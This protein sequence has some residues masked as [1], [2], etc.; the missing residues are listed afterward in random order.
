[1]QEQFAKTL[2][3]VAAVGTGV[4]MLGMTLTGALAQD[5]TLADFPKPFTT[6]TVVV[7]GSAAD[8]ADNTA[9]ADI[10]FALGAS[11]A[12]NP[13]ST[14]PSSTT[15]AMTKLEWNG[16]KMED[17]PLN[18]SFIDATDGFRSNLTDND[19][20]GFKDDV[21]RIDIGDIDDDY[22]FHEEVRFTAGARVET[23]L[24]FDSNRDKDWKE[25]IFLPMATSSVGYYFTFDES[26]K[27]G[28]YVAN[29]TQTDPIDITFLGKNLQLIGLVRDADSVTINVGEEFRLNA[30]DCVSVSGVKV[31]LKGTSS[32]KAEVDIGGQVEVITQDSSRT[33]KGVEVR[34]EDVFDEEGTSL[35]SATVFIGKDARKTYNDGQEFIGE[36][37]NDPIWVWDLAALDTASPSIGVLLNLNLDNANEDD[38]AMVKHPLYEGEYLCLPWNYA[39]IIFEKVEQKD[40]DFLKYTLQDA[41]KDLYF[42]TTDADSGKAANRTAAKV[43][44]FKAQGAN[45]NGFVAGGT[46]TD[47]VYIATGE[48]GV[49]LELYRKQQDGSKAIRF[50]NDTNTSLPL[51]NLFQIDFKST[52]MQVSVRSATKF[53]AGAGTDQFNISIAETAASNFSIYVEESAAGQITYLGHSDSDTTQGNDLH[54]Q[55]VGSAAGRGFVDISG[56]E[57]NTRGASGAIIEDPDSN[58]PSDKFVISVPPDV[59]DFKIDVRVAQPKGVGGSTSVV[60]KGTPIDGVA[61]KLDT[62]VMEGLSSW[63]VI[64]VGGPAINQ[65][66]A[67]LKGM[68]FPAYGAAS[69]I[70]PGEAVIELMKNGNNWAIIAAGYEKENTRAAGL[71]LK[72]YKD[73]ADKLKGASVVVKGVEAT[74]ITVA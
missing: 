11:S 47:T 20:D 60:T 49:A 30:G 7:V 3:K 61:S 13:S 23:G 12:S 32:T 56:Y 14:T 25:R 36:D 2:R 15:P 43:L 44:E 17:I 4:A 55:R 22:N 24:T 63:N 1:M 62:E 52:S 33:R 65:V 74:G 59:N 66:S 54:W 46:D 37:E 71:V 68:D 35:D 58:A 31:C 18:R 19:I 73:N 57:E 72:N 28:N 53:A 64:A 9:A 48:G 21:V 26:L 42:S 50:H 16:G 6:N 70:N 5:H 45:N 67:K 10:T 69:G 27:A 29:A 38:N 34:I 51:D 8:A 39:C 40:D 41:T